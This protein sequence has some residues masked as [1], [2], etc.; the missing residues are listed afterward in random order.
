MKPVSPLPLLDDRQEHVDQIA[1]AVVLERRSRPIV[2]G[3]LR[4]ALRS[5]ADLLID[6]WGLAVETD[7]RVSPAGERVPLC[8]ELGRLIVRPK[9][10]ADA[11]GLCHRIERPVELA[12]TQ[13]DP[14]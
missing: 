7:T 5:R 12:A 6:T 8:A 10:C 9:H 11:V 4:E 2:V 14:R 3:P 1:A 13:T